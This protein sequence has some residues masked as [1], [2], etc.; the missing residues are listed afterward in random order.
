MAEPSFDT[1]SYLRGS[2]RGGNSTYAI[3]RCSDLESDLVP[4]H[5]VAPNGQLSF[6]IPLDSQNPSLEDRDQ[7]GFSIDTFTLDGQRFVRLECLDF[8]LDRQFAALVDNLLSHM[9]P[10]SGQVLLAD[11]TETVA[12]WRKFFSPAKTPLD[13]SAQI[14]LLAELL[15]LEVAIKSVGADFA[16]SAWLGP[17]KTRHD[18]VG[19]L[20]DIEVKATLR[21]SRFAVSIH[22]ISQLDATEHP[23]YLVGYQFERT[24]IGFSLTKQINVLLEMTTNSALFVS[25]LFQCGVP[26]S[27]IDEYDSTQ[28]QVNSVSIHEV[29]SK[30]P[31]LRVEGDVAAI[32]RVQYDLDLGRLEKSGDTEDH[33]R[34]LTRGLVA[35]HG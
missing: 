3:R 18:F 29:D 15:V 6:L 26:L 31:R 17:D 9:D 27:D 19:A 11:I 16:L 5:A 20:L 30:F 10:I 2:H 34:L 7:V 4:S 22:G 14:G 24:A 35:R 8:S 21:R 33:V 28:V 12:N 32:S 13:T 23:L 1:Y 25:K